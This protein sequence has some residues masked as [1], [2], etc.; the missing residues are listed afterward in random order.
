MKVGGKKCCHH[1]VVREIN[2]KEQHKFARVHGLV[3]TH[4]HK[5]KSF[6]LFVD[7]DRERGRITH[8]HVIGFRDVY[9]KLKPS[10]LVVTLIWKK[11]E[12]GKRVSIIYTHF[13]TVD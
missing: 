12:R 1:Y 6:S 4:T 8:H 11:K 2:I 10:T 7:S 3:Q 9:F 5:Q 13:T